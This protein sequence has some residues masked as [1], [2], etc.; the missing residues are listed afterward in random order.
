MPHAGTFTYA[1]QREHVTYWK[2]STHCKTNRHRAMETC[3]TQWYR[4]NQKQ[5]PGS[6]ALVHY[7][8]TGND[9]TIQILYIHD[10]IEIAHII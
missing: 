4:H 7:L 10:T 8:G 9:S 5:V 2:L 1:I 6:S 3:H